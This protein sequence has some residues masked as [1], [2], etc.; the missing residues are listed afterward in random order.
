[1]SSALYYG[2]SEHESGAREESIADDGLNE[3]GSDEDQGAAE[4]V[5][6]GLERPDDSSDG[7]ELLLTF[8]GGN[9]GRGGAPASINTRGRGRGRARGRGGSR[10]SAV[11]AALA[12]FPETIPPFQ[13]VKFD[14]KSEPGKSQLRSRGIMPPSP[15]SEFEQYF[16]RGILQTIADNTN[17][18]AADKGT[19]G[20]RPWKPLLAAELKQFLG[21]VIYMGLFPLPEVSQYWQSGLGP[22]H[23]VS[24]VMNLKRF[25]Q[26]KRFIHV[27]DHR[28]DKSNEFF[29]NKLEPLMSHVRSAS[30]RR[31]KPGRRLA[32]DE[33]MIICHGKSSETVRM[34]GKPIG[35]GFKMWAICDA[36][37]VYDF[38]PHSNKDGWKFTQ[39]YKGVLMS[40]SAIV[41]TLVDTLPGGD[42]GSVQ[43]EIYMDNLFSSVK[44]FYMLRNRGKGIGCAGTTR[45]NT[46]GF[47]TILKVRGGADKKMDW[48]TLGSVVVD[49]VNCVVWVDNAA[50]LMLTT[51]HNVGPDHTVTRL[52]RRPRTTS[53]NG[54]TVRRVFGDNATK[55]LNIPQVIDDYNHFMGSVDRADQLH[56][57][58]R[59][60]LRGNRTWMPIFFWLL[61][62]SISNSFLAMKDKWP[63]EWDMRR[64]GH[65]RF[66]AA[67][68]EALMKTSLQSAAEYCLPTLLNVPAPIAGISAEKTSGSKRRRRRSSS[69]LFEDAEQRLCGA[70]HLPYSLPTTS[71]S[72]RG[73]C[74]M[75]FLRDPK[76]PRKTRTFCTSCKP[77]VF[78]C[79]SSS[80]GDAR[81]CFW[82]YH[83]L[84]KLPPSSRAASDTAET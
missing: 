61:D 15:L 37:Y 21:I 58:Y 52:R 72:S 57:N 74:A 54:S 44:L 38:F 49:G 20:G 71:Q 73:S 10:S 83:T 17:S 32:V 82:D 30:K 76:K 5:D 62:V 53:T 65:F 25:Q 3:S 36:G 68:S 18:Y 12:A 28:G 26:I 51:I 27:S 29:F 45:A 7:D 2:A 77:R 4:M 8:S 6:D 79:I 66:R 69:D 35:A 48:D 39:K 46:T 60:H 55:K 78:L 9:R 81:N 14:S 24:T 75:C 42:D 50:V 13:P 64:S 19:G 34:R 56:S 47:P 80:G 11:E 40:F 63:N 33:M 43:Y 22:V 23:S 84:S 1:M 70:D 59:T 41:A 31:W 16:S 67:L